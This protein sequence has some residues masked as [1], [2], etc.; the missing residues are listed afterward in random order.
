MSWRLRTES[1]ALLVVDVQE[2]LLPVMDGREALEK[3]LNQLIS[4]CSI[5][6]IPVYFTEQYPQGLGETLPVLRALAPQAPSI[7]KTKFSGVDIL[8]RIEAEYIVVCGIEAHV[9]VR[10][11]VYDIRDQGKEGILVAD[12]VASRSP[13]DKEIAIREMQVR[14]ISVTTVEAFLFEMLGD[15]RHPR[16][17]EISKQI[18]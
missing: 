8:C 9:C 11:T 16:F 17:K 2:K 12:A 7:E 18:R 6:G 1:T 15:S 3:R 14:G 13:F 4:G 10:Q 5:L